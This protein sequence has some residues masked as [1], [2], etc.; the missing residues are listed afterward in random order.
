[1]SVPAP[2]VRSAPA[3]PPALATHTGARRL[4][5]VLGVALLVL[6]ILAAA[7]LLRE[8]RLWWAAAHSWTQHTVVV[9]GLADDDWVEVELPAATAAALPGLRA[10]AHGIALRDDH[11]RRLVP[12]PPY[13]MSGLRDEVTLAQHPAEPGTL[14]LLDPMAVAVPLV[15]QV[16]LLGVLGVAG[17]AWR[18]LPWGR[19][20]T[21]SGG[22]W[23]ASA[24]TAHRAGLAAVPEGEL[25]EPPEHFA[26]TRFWAVV[27]ALLAAGGVAMAIAEGAR[28]P[29]ETGVV[30]LVLSGAAGL[31]A[32]VYVS[33]RTRRW[34]FDAQGLADGSW[35]QTRRLPWSAVAAFE[36]VNTNAAAQESYDADWREGR[37]RR[38]TRGRP[39]DIWQWELRA[40]DGT[41]LT[42]LPAE[43]EGQPAFQALRARLA[44]QLRPVVGEA[45]EGAFDAED[46]EGEDGEPSPA[47]R[48]EF[49]AAE[50]RFEREQRR[51]HRGARAVWLLALLPL[52]L[53]TLWGSFNAAR[54]ALAS[55]R[56]EARV[57]E[58]GR[59][60]GPA[61][62]IAWRDEGGAERRLVT[63][64]SD[65]YAKFTPG[66]T[67]TVLVRGPAPE[68]AR[69]DHFLELWLLPV[70]G[71][72][73]CAIVALPLLL[74]GGVFE[75]RSAAD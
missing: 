72:V 4:H 47:E 50:A 14:R 66:S 30:L 67:V 63:G 31:M 59:G 55:D 60:R 15:A 13:F 28:S 23:V 57:V 44:A 19:D 38:S 71:W 5:A 3:A 11:V 18:L 17:L 42:R 6:G 58:Q 2:P 48:A 8:A 75:K 37:A 74:I 61:L 7:H 24:G 64:G 12:R 35:F 73:L 52:L 9:E 39:R 36:K 40:A 69:F 45:G 29:V 54:W 10:P 41:V 56:V 51:F 53:P 1:M 62:T 27:I 46:E 70:I 16:L 32:H 68:D 26:G 34:R 43:L 21:W 49:A 22:R 20:E 33:T 25:R 65:V